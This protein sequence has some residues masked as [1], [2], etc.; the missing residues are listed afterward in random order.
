MRVRILAVAMLL[1]LSFAAPAMAAEWKV[2]KDVPF[3]LDRWIELGVKDGPVTLHRIRVTEVTG[4]FKPSELV[5][6]LNPDYMKTVRIELEYSNS[7]T[8]DWETRMA[9]EWFDSG[10]VVIDGFKGDENLDDS[11][12]HDLVTV[13]W[14]TLRYGL[15]RG[16]TLKVKLDLHA[17]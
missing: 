17:D 15:A 9:V 13:T 8:R 16:K 1:L 12:S 6:P 7:A 11:E 3:E 14:A 10:G 4:H 2:A 5:R